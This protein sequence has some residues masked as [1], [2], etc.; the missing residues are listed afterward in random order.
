MAGFVLAVA[1]TL[2]HHAV[3]D[4]P[5]HAVVQQAPRPSG[6]AL[7]GLST[8]YA[9]RSGE[10]AAGPALRAMLGKGWRGQTVL[11]NGV[12]VRLTDYMGTTNRVK[13]IDLDDGLFRRICGPL[14]RGVCK[15]TVT[16]G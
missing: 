3:P 14:S 16:R 11:V 8:W 5:P 15:V 9:Y 13:V 7:H 4:R 10:A 12:P 6:T 2:S 1:A